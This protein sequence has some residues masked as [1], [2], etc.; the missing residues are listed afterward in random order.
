MQSRPQPLSVTPALRTA[1]ETHR[2]GQQTSPAQGDPGEKSRAFGP[3][4]RRWGAAKEE[5]ARKRGYVPRAAH[6]AALSSSAQSI[7]GRT[8]VGGSGSESGRGPSGSEHPGCWRGGVGQG[9]AG[10]GGAR[11]DPAPPSGGGA[12]SRTVG[13]SDARGA[14]LAP[15]CG[16]GSGAEL[17]RSQWSCWRR[18]EP[19]RQE[20][21]HGF[22]SPPGAQRG[23][24]SHWRGLLGSHARS[25]SW[26]VF[27][28]LG[29]F[30]SRSPPLGTRTRP[31][32]LCAESCGATRLVGDT[33]DAFGG[34]SGLLPPLG[35]SGNTA[36]G[37]LIPSGVIAFSPSGQGTAHL[38]LHRNDFRGNQL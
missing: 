5:V 30:F 20:S 22:P 32:R 26:F 23:T 10:R 24:G 31:A 37:F 29:L 1:R 28:P 34:M 38:G 18:R 15:R 9:G 35:T 33:R 25:R 36:F 6:S 3:R 27:L 4:P 2:H 19:I 13:T 8:R 11:G 21:R 12:W 14:G 17:G 7:R 16:G